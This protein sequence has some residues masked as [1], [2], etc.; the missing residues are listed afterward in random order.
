MTIL[1]VDDS[2]S[3][4]LLLSSILK[5]AGYTDLIASDSARDAL[6]KLGL[7][8]DRGRADIDLVLMDISMPE[9]DGIEACRR[10]KGVDSLHDLPIIMVTAS[11]E[12]EDLQLAFDAGAIDYITKPLNKVELLARVRSSLR[13]KQEMDRRKAREA[14]LV[15]VNERLGHTLASLD[16]KH[17][18]LLA[19]QDKSERLLLNILPKAIADRLKQDQGVIADSFPNVTVLFADIVDFTRLAAHASPGEVVSLLND[20]FSRFDRLA[21]TH[22]LEKIKTIGDAY[23]VVG[24][25][26]TPR[27]DHAVAVAEMALDMRA[28][29]TGQLRQTG[30]LLN[31]RIGIHSGPVVAG[32]IGT[33]KF[34][35]DLWGDTVNIASRME[36]LGAPGAIQVSHETYELLRDHYAF[37]ARGRVNVKGKG[38]MLTYLLVNRRVNGAG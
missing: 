6:Q 33:K 14:E 8:G 15:Q 31:L 35:Y 21:E 36:S 12:P 3:Q 7:N 29:L 22:H 25:L 27:P 16:E 20:I 11:T 4:R 9:M 30:G 32:V 19:E 17:R 24:G 10:I 37:E 28:M 13:L 1:I 26:P 2:P 34:I 23:M 5:S 18:Q 38:E